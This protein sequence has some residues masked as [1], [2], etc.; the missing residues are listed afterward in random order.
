MNKS[1]GLLD[2]KMPLSTWGQLCATVAMESWSESKEAKNP[3][4]YL[5][6]CLAGLWM[7]GGDLSY[8]STEFARDIPDTVRPWL[9]RSDQVAASFSQER[10]FSQ[11]M[12]ASNQLGLTWYSALA[13]ILNDDFHE[14]FR[15]RQ[16]AEWT[17]LTHSKAV[18]YL[19]LFFVS[20]WSSYTASAIQLSSMLDH[21]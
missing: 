6:G 19:N 11:F 4:Y 12:S 20:L 13:K 9:H 17:M 1:I 14:C 15:I 5:T 2:A 21:S 18:S 7:G 10:N 16:E 8:R 3:F